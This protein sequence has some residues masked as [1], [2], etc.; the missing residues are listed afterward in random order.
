M[1]ISVGT[2]LAAATMTSVSALV[3]KIASR[4]GVFLYTGMYDFT[5]TPGGVYDWVSQSVSGF[6]TAERSVWKYSSGDGSNS[7]FGAFLQSH[8][9]VTLAVTQGGHMVPFSNPAVARAMAERFVT[10]GGTW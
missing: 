8:A 1:K 5:I 4:I 10:Q 7:Q 6:D 2:S 9:N 3:P